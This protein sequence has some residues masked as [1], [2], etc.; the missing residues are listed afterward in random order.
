MRNEGTKLKRLKFPFDSVVFTQAFVVVVEK[1]RAPDPRTTPRRI[2][3]LK[4]YNT[5]RQHRY[6]PI[7]PTPNEK[8]LIRC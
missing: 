4:R 5:S 2:A 3:L 7:M 6:T 8:V 1:E